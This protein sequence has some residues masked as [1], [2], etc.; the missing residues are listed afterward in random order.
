LLNV[1][2][3]KVQNSDECSES[4]FACDFRGTSQA[5]EPQGA[6]EGPLPTL[7]VGTANEP[8]PAEFTA[9]IRL[10]YLEGMDERDAPALVCCAARLELHGAPMNRTWLKL[11]RPAAAD[12]TAVELIEPPQGWRVGDDVIVTGFY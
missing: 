10:H 4:G 3:L 12:D 9:R 11:N 7:E 2:V 6:P 8:I 1:G 5:G